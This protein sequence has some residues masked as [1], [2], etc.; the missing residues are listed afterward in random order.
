MP[1]TLTPILVRTTRNAGPFWHIRIRRMV[2]GCDYVNFS[3]TRDETKATDN[4]LK[5]ACR[6]TE[7]STLAGFRVVDVIPVTVVERME[8]V[9]H[10]M[11]H[12]DIIESAGGGGPIHPDDLHGAVRVDPAMNRPE[13]LPH[14]SPEATVIATAHANLR[15][16]VDTQEEVFFGSTFAPDSEMEAFIAK[17]QEEVTN[18]PQSA[19]PYWGVYYIDPTTGVAEMCEWDSGVFNDAHPDY[20]QA[21]K[22]AEHATRHGG[23][24]VY[25]VRPVPAGTP[26]IDPTTDKPCKAGPHPAGAL[27]MLEPEDASMTSIIG[28][29]FNDHPTSLINHYF[30]RSFDL[31]E[32]FGFML[33]PAALYS[34]T[35]GQMYLK[36]DRLLCGMVL[37]LHLQYL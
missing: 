33:R 7:H 12:T 37:S 15:R 24:A 20:A 35:T 18:A 22:G 25:E 16:V 23:G 9:D 1:T 5:D 11:P 3:S 21:V 31:P 34:A 14:P 36:S 27:D 29:V 32:I 4:A 6:R 30:W 8:R 17:R 10:D 28:E 19:T 13:M 2:T 26:V